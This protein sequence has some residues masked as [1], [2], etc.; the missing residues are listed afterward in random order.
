M[1]EMYPYLALTGKMGLFFNLK[2]F[3]V[4]VMR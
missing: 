4:E 3:P 1:I 2:L